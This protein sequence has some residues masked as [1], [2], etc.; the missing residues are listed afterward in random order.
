[1]VIALLRGH[2]A[3]TT[4]RIDHIFNKGGKLFLKRYKANK[5]GGGG[6]QCFESKTWNSKCT[7]KVFRLLS[8]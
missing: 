3:G 5:H 6:F 1:M 2:H 4:V 7:G 8:H